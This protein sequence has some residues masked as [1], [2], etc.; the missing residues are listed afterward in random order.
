MSE[1]ILMRHG[2]KSLKNLQS[3][4]GSGQF[5]RENIWFDWG[6]SEERIVRLVGDY[7]EVRTHWIGES[8]YGQGQDIAILNASAFKGDNKI[9]M[10]V[11]CGNWDIDT[12]SEDPV[13]DNCPICRLG[14][15]A[16]SILSKH[17]KE[18]NEADKAKLKKVISKCKVKSIFM[19]KCID[20]DNPYVD[21]ER[22][23]K[24][25]KI[26]KM[27]GELFK[28]IMDLAKQVKGVSIISDDNGIDIRIKRTKPEN[29][30]GKTT[31]SASVVMSG[32]SVK[33]TPLTDE[34]RQYH[35]LDLSKFAAKPI[36]KE[37]FEEELVDDETIRLCYEDT[38]SSEP[39]DEKA[40]F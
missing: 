7:K 9:P 21:E 13:G 31:Y 37:R 5:T 38:E 8:K 17:G 4:S 14:R 35:D 18:L 28:S 34:E 36:D 25:Y 23:K 19:F 22:T 27:P 30:K 1:D 33:Q 10:N 26:I 16:D 40:P 11:G 6:D 29:G 3:N 32:L 20:R 12:E 39:A 15:N 2:A 24:G